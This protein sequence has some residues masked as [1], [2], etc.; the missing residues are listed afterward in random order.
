MTTISQRKL[1]NCLIIVGHKAHMRGA[2][3]L[4]YHAKSSTKLIFF[5]SDPLVFA[6]LIWARWE[7]SQL[8]VSGPELKQSCS[9]ICWYSSLFADTLYN[10]V[11]SPPVLGNVLYF[12]LIL[13]HPL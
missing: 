1:L 10:V 8:F 6:A 4:V 11:F 3:N 9:D 5:G 7:F 2:A 13:R 12:S